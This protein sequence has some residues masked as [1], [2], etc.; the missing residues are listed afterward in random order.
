VSAR[1]EGTVGDPPPLAGLAVAVTRP[2][3]GDEPLGRALAALGA[4]VRP[5]PMLVIEPPTDPA[6]LERAL[7][8]WPSYDWV[9][10]TS[11]RGV[12]AVAE[13][14]AARGMDPRE[15]PPR[16]LAVVGP[17]TAAAARTVGWTAD[18][19]PDRF[20]AEGL[21]GALERR[22]GSLAGARVLVPVAEAARETLGAGLRAR[23]A[24][25]DQVAAYRS[26]AP[27][28]FDESRAALLLEGDR[29]LLITLASPSAARN[30]LALLGPRVLAFP[31]AAIGPVTG[32]AARALG[33]TVVAQPDA[34]TLEALAEAVLEWWS[35]R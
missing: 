22:A 19:V 35:E 1:R 20:D 13:A 10:F 9:A 31:A 8:R 32:D 25:V 14:L 16:R 28:G 4:E 27:A 21:L 12:S 7:A 23:G 3:A 29:P 24:H 6:P 30:L 15:R 5:L 33:Y 2:G 17:T 11:P 34:H 26:A 18:V